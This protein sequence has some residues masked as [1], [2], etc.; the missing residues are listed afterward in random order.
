MNPSFVKFFMQKKW[1]AVVALAAALLGA[2]ACAQTLDLHSRT[3]SELVK[4]KGDWQ[5][6]EQT[7][8]WNPKQTAMVICDMWNQHWC[9]GATARVAE[10]APRMNKVIQEARR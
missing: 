6:T 9:K 2:Q 8:H 7:V 3:R 4:G 1:S 5:M 10:M